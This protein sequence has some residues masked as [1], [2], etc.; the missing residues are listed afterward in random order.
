MILTPHMEREGQSRGHGAE[1][2]RGLAAS[3][4][5]RRA[6]PAILLSLFPKPPSAPPLC[7]EQPGIIRLGSWIL[8]LFLQ[9][10]F[11][12]SMGGLGPPVAH[13]PAQTFVSESEGP[14]HS[15]PCPSLSQTPS[16]LKP[17]IFLLFKASSQKSPLASLPLPHLIPGSRRLFI[18]S[19]VPPT[20]LHPLPR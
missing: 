2:E 4:H 18:H 15:F 1:A 14:F 16:I 7:L 3:S 10:H 11:L 9:P 6:A 12:S 8:P 5:P 17:S 20:R 13:V 19:N